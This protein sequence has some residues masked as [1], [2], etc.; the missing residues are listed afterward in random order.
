MLSQFRFLYENVA[1]K[2][3]QRPINQQSQNRQKRK[4]PL[5]FVFLSA[6]SVITGWKFLLQSLTHHRAIFILGE[7][8]NELYGRT[9]SVLC[10]L[11]VRK[12][13]FA[14]MKKKVKNEFQM[15]FEE[16]HE[17]ILLLYSL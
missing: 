2:K 13:S 9:L 16:K 5:A 17:I 6:L 4:T 11:K 10:R 1:T 15:N 7:S 8:K 14:L 12:T 3:Q